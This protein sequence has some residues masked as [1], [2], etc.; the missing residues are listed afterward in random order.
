MGKGPSTN[1]RFTLIS[2]CLW[3]RGV[4]AL[5]EGQE[6]FFLPL[7]PFSR[8][9]LFVM[10]ILT[11]N[12]ATCELGC[13]IVQSDRRTSSLMIVL[14][15]LWGR[16]FALANICPSKIITLLLGDNSYYRYH[17]CLSYGTCCSPS[18]RR[19]RNRDFDG[20]TEVGKGKAV[21]FS[22]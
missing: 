3:S 1:V 18:A 16:W 20:D 13:I 15:F 19:W 12:S 9:P 6:L 21:Y 4:A 11:R 7:T 22:F 2:C 10:R 17:P 5:E 8:P 14:I